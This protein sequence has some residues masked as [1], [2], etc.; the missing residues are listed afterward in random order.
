MSDG[1]QRKINEFQPVTLTF[2]AE[3]AAQY[4]LYIKFGGMMYDMCKTEIEMAKLQEQISVLKEELRK[5]L[6]LNAD[7]VNDMTKVKSDND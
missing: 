5:A 3:D 1:N 7:L 4:L 2:K 6:L